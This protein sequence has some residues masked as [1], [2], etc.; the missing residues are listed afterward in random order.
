ME[1]MTVRVEVWPVAADRVPRGGGL[2][3]ASGDSAW[4]PA[5]PVPA[6]SDPHG[7][8]ELL[9]ASHGLR[10]ASMDPGSPV[11][12]LHSTSWRPSGTAIV[13]TYIAE[14]RCPGYVRDTYPAAKPIS[15]DLAALIGKP[16]TVRATEPPVPT[17]WHVLLHALRHLRLLTDL[18]SP[19]YD[20]EVT[21]GMSR[22][23]V[24]HLAAFSPALAG[25]YDQR[26]A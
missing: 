12:M 4:Q 25:M 11:R 7:E 16:E 10:T 9:L 22:E 13:L 5:L 26:A 21:A 20:A 3:L 6:D 1:N 17:E 23:M 24:R 19:A 2:W 8:V 14:I 18:T 15:L